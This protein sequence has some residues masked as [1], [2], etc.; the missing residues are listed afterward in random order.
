VTG[1]VYPGD[2]SGVA[3]ILAQACTEDLDPELE[4][5]SLQCTGANIFIQI[6]GNHL[7]ADL[8]RRTPGTISADTPRVTNPLD[9]V[10]G[11]CEALLTALGEL[12]V[13][14]IPLN[15]SP[16][17]ADARLTSLPSPLYPSRSYWIVNKSRRS[18]RKGKQNIVTPEPTTEALAA[19][20]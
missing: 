9:G 18:E 2:A 4:I 12:V 17:F 3:S 6:G 14:G 5:S 10:G 1:G 15:L 8:A 19:T 11:P 7:P 16:L 13:Q 20:M